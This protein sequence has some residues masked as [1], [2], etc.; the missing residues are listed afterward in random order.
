MNIINGARSLFGWTASPESEFLNLK[1]KAG[2]YPPLPDDS[3]N[4][5]MIAEFLKKDA[6]TVT[7]TEIH[8]ARIAL[9]AVMPLDALE[10]QYDSLVAEYIGVTG[11]KPFAHG[12]FP[13]PPKTIEGW[14]AGVISLMEN[15]TKF[16]RTKLM[17]ERV[18][19]VVGLSFGLPLTALVIYA[20]WFVQKEQRVPSSTNP[21][22]LWMP[23][24]FTGLIGA[25]FSV[26]SRLYGLTWSPRVAGQIE[27]VQALKKG[28]VINCIISLSEGLIASAVLYLLFTSH[29]I[30][31]KLFPEF[32]DPDSSQQ[33]IFFRFLSS[34]PKE[35]TD[36]AKL[37]AWAFVAGFSERF[38]PDK[39]KQ[40]AGK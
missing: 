27:D 39:L 29:L 8:A 4:K 36:V 25:G 13:V 14:R 28:L 19:S 26:L 24:L 35:A 30:G 6:K 23:L 10:T 32:G 34:Q 9:V 18:R 16:R 3:A 40:L 37:L 22:P 7:W 15:L 17:F 38:I 11:E 12:A 5:P 33:F 31:G 1:A 2:V 21:I 20:F